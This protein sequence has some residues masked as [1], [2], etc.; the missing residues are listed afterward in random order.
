MPRPP[1][2][3]IENPQVAQTISEHHELFKIV[4]PFN[5]DRFEELLFTHPNQPFVKSVCQ[6][7]REGFWPWANT[8]QDGYPLTHDESFPT[9]VDPVKAQFLRDQCHAEIEKDRFSKSFG[10]DLLPGMYSMPIHAV[11]KP[12]SEDLRM[13]TDQSAGPFSLNSMIE[14]HE[15]AF[16]LDNM[17]HLGEAILHARKQLKPNAELILF[18]SDV[19]EAYRNIPMHPCWQ[20]KQVNTINNLRFIDRNNAFGGMRSGDLWIAFMSLVVWIARVIRFIRILFAYVDDT[21]GLDH[22]DHL[23]WYPPYQKH[24]PDNQTKLL[25]LWDELRIPHKE[26]KQISGSP[27]T[28]IGI[29]VDPNNLT[30]TL[31]LRARQDLIRELHRFALDDRKKGGKFTVR[32][33]QRMAGWLNWAFNVFPLLRPCLNNLYPKI[34]GRTIRNQKIWTNNAIR[35]DMLWALHYVEC[36]PGVRIIRDCNWDPFSADATIFC[37]ACISGMGFWYPGRCAGY[38]SLVPENI[39]SE[40]IFYREALCVTSAIHHF[41]SQP[42]LSSKKLVIYTDNT[43][44]VDIF[45]SLK[46]LP[47]YN[48]LLRHTVDLLLQNDHQLR[49]I[50]VPGKLNL[51]ADALSRRQPLRAIQLVPHLS[52]DLFEPPRAALGL[53]K[54]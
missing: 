29:D 37:D 15:H 16:P 30:L 4:C 54:K 52:I 18:K 26:K 45:N 38:Y 20:I 9:P 43:N 27:L 22:C 10:H 34:A 17:T 40:W 23:T 28:I 8:R 35:S 19:S 47:P 31:P 3:E 21:F 42:Q 44:T 14:P 32:D 46:C 11:P 5:I 51:V 39:P 48:S 1:L 41:F 49:V 53:V 12:N 33:F 7:L 2:S 25:L 36:L 24:L 13:V 50:H 6:G